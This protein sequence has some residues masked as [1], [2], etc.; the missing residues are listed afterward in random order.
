M[1]ESAPK[2]ATCGPWVV[3]F[4]DALIQALSIVSFNS[5]YFSVTV[6][7]PIQ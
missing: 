4:G 5:Q 3:E 1:N 6:C 2:Q 7:Q